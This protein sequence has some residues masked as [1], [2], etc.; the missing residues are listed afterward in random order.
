MEADQVMMDIDR[1]ETRRYPELP[2]SRSPKRQYRKERSDS[3]MEN[4]PTFVEA[5]YVR[6]DI[7]AA[8]ACEKCRASKR[9]CDKTLPTCDR[10]TR[11]NAK[12]HYLKEATYNNVNPYGP[13]V[14]FYQSR[15]LGSDALFRGSEPLDGIAVPQILS[16]I[17]ADTFPGGP[18][19]AITLFFNC[20]HSWFAVIHP[21][22]FHR[23]AQ[24]ILAT[25]DSQSQSDPGSPPPSHC[26]TDDSADTP[27]NVLG[28]HTSNTDLS[29]KILAL[30]VVLMHL[31]I[32]MRLTD[33]GE[34]NMFDETYRTVKRLLAMLLMG[35]ADGPP[36]TI[37]LVQCGALMALYEYG[38]GRIETAYQSLVQTAAVAHVLKITPSQRAAEYGGHAIPMSLE[39]EQRTCLWWG[40]FILEQFIL[41]DETTRHLPFNFESPTQQTL[42]PETP[43]VTPA[44]STSDHLTSG[45]A[46]TP[47]TILP[48]AHLF[49][50]DVRLDDQHLSGFQLSAKT[51]SI[52]HK[53]LAI[54]KDRDKRPG[55]MPVG[56]TYK[57]L[58]QEIRSAT[59]TLLTKSL[60]WEMSLDCFAMLISALFVLYL[61]YLPI[62]ERSSPIEI[63]TN[64]E[65]T[66]ALGALWFACKMS[67]DISCKINQNFTGNSRSPA[68]LCAP[69]GA[70]CYLVIVAFV[71]FCRIYPEKYLTCQEAI[72]EKF[73]SLWLFSFRWGIAERMMKQLE[74]KARLDRKYY[75]RNTTFTPPT[76]AASYDWGR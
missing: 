62:L 57:E 66:L 19:D 35:C 42:L 26:S 3:A 46:T 2:A 37:E 27:Q 40:L 22:L 70:T 60:D 45:L 11:L 47:P 34:E 69:V 41:Q 50:T 5:Q 44:A 52:F 43:P 4:R 59:G 12:C 73:E 18:Q 32:R 21:T 75:L 6:G 14:V 53:A 23:Q 10:C 1:T 25:V 28:A 55:K 15:A 51:A 9:K 54:D 67:T 56:A 30:L 71:S 74:E 24:S 61:P 31:N 13:P 8:R 20:I 38:H 48:T 29:S 33:A 64:E 76:S 16:L 72:T 39:E 68:V 58:D 49:T 17:C 7:Q 63:E 65:L 36:P